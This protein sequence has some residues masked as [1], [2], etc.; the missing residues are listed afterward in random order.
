MLTTLSAAFAAAAGASPLSVL[1]VCISTFALIIATLNYRR[2]AGVLVRGTFSIASSR[3]S[4][5]AYVSRIALENLKD[6]AITIF[7]IYLRLGH[8]NYIKLEDRE[9]GPLIL[10]AFETY[11]AEFGPIEFY[12]INTNKLD[13]NKLFADSALT[14]RLVLST[15]EGKYVASSKIRRWSPLI[16]YFKNYFTAVALPVYA[17]Y[18]GKYVGGNIKYVI[19]IIG[20][21]SAPEIIL[22][23]PGDYEIKV[24]RNFALSRQS[25]ESKES[26]EQLLQEQADK[27]T[28]NCKSL[29]V[30]DMEAWRARERE[31]Y[32]GPKI[33]AISCGLFRYHI[34]GRLLTKYQDWSVKRENTK[35][36]TGQPPIDSKRED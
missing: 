32:S 1:A 15:S 12:G 6:R 34:V 18:G 27:G 28:L 11:A 29:M 5:D 36:L 2:K 7:A 3:A 20:V 24:F 35:R 23:H 16:E 26:L 19:E 25:L 13:L 9:G 14:K 4:D 31:F 22:I 17:T 8:N 10:R 30:Y 21:A 33:E